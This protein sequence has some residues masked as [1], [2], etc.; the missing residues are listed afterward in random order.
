MRLCAERLYEK[1]REGGRSGGEGRGRCGEER[2][3][4]VTC[5]GR[6]KGGRPGTRGESH[7]SLEQSSPSRTPHINNTNHRCTEA[8]LYLC[9]GP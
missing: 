7:G 9:I 1:G 3:L 6:G 5:V 8:V 2:G 4:G